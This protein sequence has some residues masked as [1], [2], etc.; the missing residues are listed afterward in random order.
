MAGIYRSALFVS[1]TIKQCGVIAVLFAWFM[2]KGWNSLAIEPFRWLT[3]IDMNGIWL[4]SGNFMK[5]ESAKCNKWH[6]VVYSIFK[7]VS[8]I[9]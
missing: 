8:F 7:F 6:W 2:V 5:N 3:I 1:Q 4:T 9:N